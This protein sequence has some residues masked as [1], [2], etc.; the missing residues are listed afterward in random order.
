M[1]WYCEITVNKEG[2]EGKRKLSNEWFKSFP[3]LLQ[4]DE[5][6]RKRLQEI[7]STNLR[8]RYSKHYSVQNKSFS[9]A[10]YCSVAT[11]NINLF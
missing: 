10:A 3:N 7:M 6:W 8:K 5:V 1:K 2:I 4:S 9:E 11:R